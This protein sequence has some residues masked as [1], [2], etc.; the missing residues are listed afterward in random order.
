MTQVDTGRMHVEHGAHPVW[1]QAGH[2][3]RHLGEMILAMMVGM[4]AGGALLALVFSTLLA[5]TIREMTRVEVVNQFAVLICSVVAVGMVVPMVAWMRHRGMAW[6]PVAEMA[7]AMVVP[8]V[9]IFVLLGLQIIPGASACGLYCAA[10]IPAMIVAML[11]RLEFY[12]G[13]H[14]GHG[15]KRIHAARTA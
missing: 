13:G 4:A 10:M 15:E 2:F 3:L 5:S 7:V 11:L 8:L 1:I 12:T 6:R 14:T 9:P